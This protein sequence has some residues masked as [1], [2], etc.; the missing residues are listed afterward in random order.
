M[1]VRSGTI[2][3][4]LPNYRTLTTGDVNADGFDEVIACGANQGSGG[5]GVRVWISAAACNQAVLVM[6]SVDE[7]SGTA[8]PVAADF[9]G[10]GRDEILCTH[11]SSGFPRLTIVP[12]AANGQL[13]TPLPDL[14]TG[15]DGPAANV[16]ADFDQDGAVDL[17]TWRGTDIVLLTNTT[18][19]PSS[20]ISEVFMESPWSPATVA[21]NYVWVDAESSSGSPTGGYDH[22]YGTITAAVAAAPAGSAI[23]VR[24]G[25]YRNHASGTTSEAA[26]ITLDGV[27]LIG[28]AGPRSTVIDHVVFT[29]LNGARLSGFTLRACGGT[30]GDGIVNV[31]DA[32]VVGNQLF[33]GSPAE[34]IVVRAGSHTANIGSNIVRGFRDGILIENGT[35]SGGYPSARIYHNTLV[36]NADGIGFG[37]AEAIE[38]VNNLIIENRVSGIHRV[39]FGS[40]T[41]PSHLTSLL[42]DYNW[43]YGL[44]QNDYETT[45][46][47][48]SGDCYSSITLQAGSNDR[49]A[50]FDLSWFANVAA[51]DFHLNGLQ[52]VDL[53]DPSIAWTQWFPI[54]VDGDPRSVRALGLPPVSGL[55]PDLGA[56]EVAEQALGFSS[57]ATTWYFTTS[58]C[59]TCVDAKVV[60]TSPGLRPGL[61]NSVMLLSPFTYAGVLSSGAGPSALTPVPK[62]PELAGV[63]LYLQSVVLDATA[64]TATLSNALAFTAY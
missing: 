60:A 61:F 7:D 32:T 26:E 3:G 34:G 64:S 47:S 55:A 29:C 15:G 17:A 25:H 54:D 35:S 39:C 59:P 52:A 46:T 40:P 5:G 49:G 14:N 30:A 62:L 31:Y 63:R 19:M 11:N 4:N 45:Y 22:P 9:D 20:A 37:A 10:D 2:L 16:A 12:T 33:G 21:P 27:Q 44:I 51:D 43:V 6:Y 23:L 1:F 57:D 58:M 8:Y 41:Q 13:L 18:A 48:G 53:G 50:P 24:P 28:V 56:D 38:I 36:D 42:V